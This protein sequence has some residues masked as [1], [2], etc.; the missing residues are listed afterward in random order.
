MAKNEIEEKR[1]NQEIKRS[2]KRDRTQWL[3]KLAESGSWESVKHL[4]RPKKNAQ[5][6]L[7]DMNGNYVFSHERD[8]SYLNILRNFNGM[9]VPMLVLLPAHPFLNRYQ[10]T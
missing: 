5:G 6:R 7:M 1:L 4:R 10:S 8:D 3:E 9:P 2:A